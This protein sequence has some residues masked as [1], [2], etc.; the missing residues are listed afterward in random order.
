VALAANAGIDIVR[1]H[2]VG[3]QVDVVR[4]TDAIVRGWRPAGWN[5]VG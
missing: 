1:V 3:P 2:D 5:A 4:V